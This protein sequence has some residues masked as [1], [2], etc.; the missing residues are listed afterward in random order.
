MPYIHPAALEYEFKRWM[1]PDAHRF[2]RPDWR[3][4]VKPGSKL[5]TLYES[6]ERKY[7]PNEPRDDHGRWTDE[8]GSAQGTSNGEG[9]SGGTQVAGTVIYICIAGSSSRFTVGG[10]QTYSVTY[11]CAGGRSFVRTGPGHYFPT[12]VIDPFH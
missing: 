4:F 12:I 8:S 2:I 5:E 3:R 1:R 7:N 10:I 11:E 9:D 6:I